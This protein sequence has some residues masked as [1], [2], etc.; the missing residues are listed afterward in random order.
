MGQSALNIGWSIGGE[1]EKQDNWFFKVMGDL[2][3]SIILLMLLAQNG[4]LHT[5]M[6]FCFSIV[7]KGEA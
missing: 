5:S 1:H 3:E 4:N 2:S 6:R 7:F